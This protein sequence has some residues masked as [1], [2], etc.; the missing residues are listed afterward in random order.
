MSGKRKEPVQDRYGRLTFI[1]WAESK[2]LLSGI[3]VSQW[4]MLCDC[5][6][7]KVVGANGVKSARIRSCGCLLRE[8]ASAN[9]AVYREEHGKHPGSTHGMTGTPIFHSWCAMRQRTDPKYW[10]TNYPEYE[11][12]HCCE[13]WK[14]F[15]GFMANQPPG[16]PH[17]DGLVL[18]RF[19]DAGNY[20]PD[21]CR[22]TTK[23]ANSRESVER[24]MRKLPDGRFAG[25]VAVANG[26][27]RQC[28]CARL[29]L[30]W[31]LEDAATH[32]TMKPGANRRIEE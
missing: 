25:D 13:E 28:F 30:G 6:T 20:E 11:G 18:A 31:G 9:I 27:S 17:E 7:V 12:V 8:T 22:W 24:I 26:I 5:G 2:R 21:N 16:R 32:P 23:S 10:L 3:F 29:K 14:T 1:R 15:Q 4:E 19:G